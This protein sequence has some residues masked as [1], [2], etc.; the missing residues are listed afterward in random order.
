MRGWGY[1]SNLRK[2]IRVLSLHSSGIQLND[3]MKELSRHIGKDYK[4]LARALGIGKTDIDS[5]E[6]AN[7]G[8]LKEQIAQFFILWQR[9]EGRNATIE[10]LKQALREAELL[11]ALDNMEKFNKGTVL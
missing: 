4:K 9:K 7:P 2:A 1:V 11:E 3:F 6:I 5:L 8:D 10:R